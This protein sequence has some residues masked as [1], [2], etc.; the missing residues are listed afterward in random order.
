MR[1]E[2]QK[3]RGQL[4]FDLASV[5]EKTKP[6]QMDVDSVSYPK[7]V[8]IVGPEMSSVLL[9]RRCGSLLEKGVTTISCHRLVLLTKRSELQ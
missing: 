8:K 9:N 4:F 5:K 1:L 7:M 6:V 2:R 3:A